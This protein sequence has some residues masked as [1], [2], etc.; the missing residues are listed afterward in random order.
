LIVTDNQDTEKVLATVAK[1][2]YVF[3]ENNPDVFIYAT[4]STVARTRLY[5]IMLTRHYKELTKDYYLYGQVGN[6]FV[7]FK[8]G[9]DFDE[10]LAQRK[11]KNRLYENERT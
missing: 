4:G 9:V 3:F 5:R 1:A 6:Q 10:F 8:P 11:F 2:V 7:E